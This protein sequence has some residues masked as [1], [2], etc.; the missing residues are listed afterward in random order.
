M[1][2]LRTARPR[3]SRRSPEPSASGS[4]VGTRT[5]CKSHG[6]RAQCVARRAT[7]PVILATGDVHLDTRIDRE[8]RFL[9]LHG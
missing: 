8:R 1:T 3:A 9:R 7:V 5:T 2:W 4:E 6:A